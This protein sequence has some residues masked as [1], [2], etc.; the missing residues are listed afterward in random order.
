M[1]TSR[2]LD[3]PIWIPSALVKELRQGLRTP[4]F[5]VMISLFPALLALFFLFSFII[6]P[7]DG[8]PFISQRSC[9]SIFWGGLS[10]ALLFIMPFRALSGVREEVISRNSELL[11][12][13][14]QSAGRIILGKW[15]SFMSQSLLIAFISLPFCLIR[16]Y[17][18]QIDLMQDLTIFSYIYMG[19]GILTALSL[20]ASALPSLL[21]FM[22]GVLLGFIM[23]TLLKN[24]SDIFQE[25]LWENPLSAFIILADVA[26]VIST[27]LIMAGEWFA[28]PAQNMAAPLRKLLLAFFAVSI[29]PLPFLGSATASVRNTLDSHLLFLMGYSIF[30]MVVNLTDPAYLL[31]IHVK[32]M[33]GKMFSTLQQFLFLPGL[34]GGVFFTLL[35]SALAFVA[36]YLTSLYS[37]QHASLAFLFCLMTGLWYAIT[38][39]AMLLKPFWKKLQNNTIL[40]YVLVWLLLFLFLQV[41]DTMKISLPLLPG[42][43]LNELDNSKNTSLELFTFFGLINMAAGFIMLYFT[44]RRWFVVRKK[45]AASSELKEPEIKLP[46]ME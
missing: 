30:L 38:M 41:L 12:L 33:K 23:I 44:N 31:P 13:T 37:Y 29:I 22:V 25:I 3:F 16:Y 24:H 32:Q 1:N 8:E 27:L 45:A 17:Y 42:G 19:S 36:A 39:P 5:V 11:L 21:R 9:N 34:P 10:V 15:I 2:S 43:Y 28:P 6:N 26:L 40:V 7:L 46:E 18:G 4:S 20:W 14:S 35:L